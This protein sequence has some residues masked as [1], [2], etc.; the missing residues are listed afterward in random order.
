VHTLEREVRA[1]DRGSLEAGAHAE[2]TDEDGA[3]V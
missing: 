2:E 3:L 1:V